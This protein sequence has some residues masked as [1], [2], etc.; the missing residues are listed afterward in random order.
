[1]QIK[2]VTPENY[3][4]DPLYR[5]V[6]NAVRHLQ[7]TKG[8]VTPINVLLTLGVLTPA[9]LLDWQQGRIF[10]LEAALRS[11]LSKT[12]RILRLLRQHARDLKLRPIQVEYT[13]SGPGPRKTLQFA[14][15]HDPNIERA[16]ARKYVVSEETTA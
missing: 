10:F 13:R 14:K 15:S 6:V 9:K 2:N 11:N 3:K 16:Y 8:E 7:Q 1:M 12:N 5:R 4:D